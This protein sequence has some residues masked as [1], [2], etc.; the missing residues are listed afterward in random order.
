MDKERHVKILDCT[1]RDG[2]YLNDWKFDPKM[3]REVYRA[4][5]KGGVD[6][7]EIGFRGTEKYFDPAKFGPWRFSDESDVQEATANISGAKI[8]LMGDY[9][10]IDVDDFPDA[11]E[12]VVS[13][14]RVASHK[15]TI[16]DSV[17]LL[18][19][20]KAKGYEVSLNAMGI[21]T[22]SDQEL[23]T[24]VRLLHESNLDYIYLADS[25]G[26]LFPDRIQGLVAPLLE[27]PNI[28]VGFHP[29]NNLQMAFANTLEAIRCGV[30]IVDSTMFGMGRGAGNLPTEI[31]LSYLERFRP[32]KYNPIPVLNCIDLY[33]VGYERDHP[34]GYQLPYMVSGILGCHPN[35]AHNMIERRRYTM[36]EIWTV[37]EVVRKRG[38]VGFKPEL[39]EEIVERGFV[40]IED[41]EPTVSP[42]AKTPSLWTKKHAVPYKDRHQGRNFLVLANGPTLREFKGKI[43]TLIDEMDPVVLGANYLGGLFTPDYHAF[44]SVKRFMKYVSATSPSSQLLVGENI[45]P[46]IIQEYTKRS[47]GTLYFH[48]VLNTEFDIDV[49]GIIQ[50]NC[51]TVS[52]LLLGLAIVMG[53]KRVFGVGFDGYVQADP[54]GRLFFYEEEDELQEKDLIISTH[55]WCERH[56]S[57]IDAY[58]KNQGGDGVHILTPTGYKAFYKG[59][60]NY[61]GAETSGLYSGTGEVATG[62]TEESGVSRG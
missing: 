24:L 2:G 49:N 27:I 29:H 45:E 56:I 10:K 23:T 19:A 53:A 17:R 31:L 5:S 40:G 26:S 50:C 52:V 54:E 37:L 58:M 21:A 20:I 4:A 28:Q 8:A 1:I 3:V 55:K 38:E 41:E 9:G 12:S 42:K 13:I 25:Y 18:Q 22:Y 16:E 33:F 60:E 36:E 11:S 30:H 43:Q 61:L 51:R 48:D 44:T 57:G 59:I 15:N 34:W 47:Y 7:V 46:T 39:V 62:Q 32:E 35:Y 14:V 6:I